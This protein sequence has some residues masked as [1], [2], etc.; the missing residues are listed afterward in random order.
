MF[1][2]ITLLCIFFSLLPSQ[3]I[4]QLLGNKVPPFN[5]MWSFKNPSILDKSC[6]HRIHP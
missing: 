5:I 2:P 1:K 6:I 4:T 3:K